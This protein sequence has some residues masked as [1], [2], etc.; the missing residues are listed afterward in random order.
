M[1]RW[2]KMTSTGD[3][4][5]EPPK[6]FHAVVKAVE[7]KSFDIRCV[8]AGDCVVDPIMESKSEN[9]TSHVCT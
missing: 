9:Y 8:A 6:C 7:G 4:S 5:E 1:T 3:S 2:I